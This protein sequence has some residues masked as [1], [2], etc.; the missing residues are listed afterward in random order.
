MQQRHEAKEGQPGMPMKDH[1]R[2]HNK[3]RGSKNDDEGKGKTV[4]E[5]KNAEKGQER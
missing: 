4:L 2:L 3:S 5:K 1:Q